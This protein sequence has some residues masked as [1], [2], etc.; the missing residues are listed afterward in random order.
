VPTKVETTVDGKSICLR[1]PN[2][3]KRKIYQ[4]EVS[5]LHDVKGRPLRNST[6]YYTLNELVED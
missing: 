4:F 1:M 3:E 6:A 2:L 5:G